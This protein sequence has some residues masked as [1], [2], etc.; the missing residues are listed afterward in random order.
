M[1]LDV[2][3]DKRVP[4]EKL[5]ELALE[6]WALEGAKQTER[7]HMGRDTDRYYRLEFVRVGRPKPGSGIAEEFTKL[8]HDFFLPGDRK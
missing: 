5:I 6:G 4:P 7:S 1:T 8:L 2:E 3:L